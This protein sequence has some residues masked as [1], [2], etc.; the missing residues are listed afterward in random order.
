MRLCDSFATS[1][2]YSIAVKWYL[3][4]WTI[5]IEL[6]VMEWIDRMKN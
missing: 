6:D 1:G 2:T 5:A 4:K 3:H